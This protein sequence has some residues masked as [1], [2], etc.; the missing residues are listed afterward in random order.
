MENPRRAQI[1]FAL[2][3]KLEIMQVV[4]FLSAEI[5]GYIVHMFLAVTQLVDFLSQ[6]ICISSMYE[7]CPE[8]KN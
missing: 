8:S 6:T 5:S 3:H 4:H 2:R 7:A 1:S